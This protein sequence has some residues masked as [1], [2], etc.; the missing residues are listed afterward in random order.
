MAADR[1]SAVLD[2]GV[3]GDEDSAEGVLIE[4][5]VCGNRMRVPAAWLGRKKK[6]RRCGAVL[7]L[8][9]GVAPEESG[10]Q[11]GLNAELEAEL[12]TLIQELLRELEQHPEQSALASQVSSRR[13][14]KFEQQLKVTDPL[15]RDEAMQRRAA[16]IE[17]GKTRDA[18]AIGILGTAQHDSWEAVRQGVATALGELADSA[19]LPLAL[20]LLMDSHPEVI[21]DTIGALREIGDPR[22]VPILLIF[23]QRDAALRLQSREAVVGMGSATVEKLIEIAQGRN[24]TLVREAVVALGRIR[25]ARAIPPLLNTLDRSTGPV[26]A[27]VV[28]ALGRIADARAV[29][30]L[31]EL[32]D[33]PSEQIQIGAASALAQTP[34]SRA[35]RPL[36]GILLQTQNVDL[37]KQAIRALAATKDPRGVMAIARL[38]DH[39]DASLRE[40]IAEGLGII[41]DKAACQ[42]L[43]RLLRSEKHSVLLKAIS[44]LR[45]VATDDAVEAL[46]PLVQHPN[47]SI[48]RQ[49]IEVLGDLRP[50]DAFDLFAEL[51]SED[52]SFEVRAAAAKG[53]GKLRDKHGI[54][55]LEQALRDEPTVR[56]AALMGLTTIGEKNV[57]PAM[58]AMLRDP[59]PVVRYHAVTGLGKLKAEQAT[60][61]IRRL[62]EDNDSMVRTGVEKALVEL[63]ISNPQIPLQRRMAIRM[64]KLMPDNLVGIV[65]GGVVTIIA[66]PC[67]MGLLA[68]GWF[69]TK[70]ALPTS[71]LELAQA[72]ISTAEVSE[73]AWASDADRV[74]LL[75]I[76]G[77][78]D[79]WNAV[80]GEFDERLKLDAPVQLAV[81]TSADPR[82]LVAYTG[83]GKTKVGL[84]DVK[85]GAGSARKIDWAPFDGRIQSAIASGD[86]NTLL[87]ITSPKES[88]IWNVA[89][90]TSVAK[91]PFK[92]HPR[93]ALSDDGRIVAGTVWE[94][95]DP[96]LP[97]GGKA[98]LH[99]YSAE[100]GERLTAVDPEKLLDIQELVFSPDGSKLF[101]ATSGGLVTLIL[102][103]NKSPA[104]SEPVKIPT[105]RGLRPGPDSSLIGVNK[106]IVYQLNAESGKAT[107]FRISVA[108][109]MKAPDCQKALAC[110]DGSRLLVAGEESKSAWLIDVKSGE[111]TELNPIAIPESVRNPR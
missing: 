11:S 65:P 46:I 111:S 51:L 19:C 80:T 61:A 83:G 82:V 48:R 96:N 78:I 9:S 22:A 73:I 3:H 37:Q 103:G 89:Q 2:S 79:V 38:I 54:Q 26:R 87:A 40:G 45:K 64:G 53:L 58:L 13:L 88:V 104:I 105:L 50:P 5:C 95:P 97:T 62:L 69:V 63:G 39:A 57:I 44:A 4:Q 108:P 10:I 7:I 70:D 60:G 6:C 106:T 41:G 8:G 81:S 25:D 90:K 17:L 52:V 107:Q 77:S 47:P 101:A 109:G 29:G 34:D 42:P 76:D 16:V 93:P 102:D 74:A 15:S 14:S 100:T 72:L 1:E 56:C 68:A 66:V 59:T 84:W 30:P 35:V 24:E 28:E 110:A 99:I 20:T 55:L 27:A 94:T 31:I 92:S 86:G 12:S 33:D 23:G 75:R 43:V 18:R 36:M 67:L 32:L 98:V 71:D 49:T 91:V 21:R 85:Q